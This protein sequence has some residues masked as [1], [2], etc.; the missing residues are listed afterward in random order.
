SRAAATLLGCN[1]NTRSPASS[2]RSTTTPSGRSIATNT[3]LK[4]TSVPH[5]PDSPFSSCANVAASTCWPVSSATS[6]SCLSDAQSIPAYRHPIL[7]LP[8][9]L[10]FT[11]PRP[12]GTVADPHRQGPQPRGYVLL[13]LAAP[14]HRRDGLVYGRPSTQG[15]GI[16]ALSRR[17]SRQPEDVL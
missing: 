6:T 12:R 5:N 16:A 10:T 1:A 4:R 17:R 11:A 3:T 7:H 9:S 15:Q 14:H 2:S 13:P 8:R